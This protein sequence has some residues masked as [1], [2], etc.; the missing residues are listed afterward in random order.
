MF[1]F[2]TAD[3]K[4]LT[5]QQRQRYGAV[6][7]GICRAIRETANQTARLSLQYDMAFLALLLSSLYEPEETG[8]KV[9]CLLHPCRRDGWADNPYIRYAADLNV[10]LA[11]YKARDDVADEGKLSARLAEPVLKKPMAAIEARW[12]RQTQA[13]A[14]CIRQLRQLEEANCPNPDLPAACFGQLMAQLMVYREDHWTPYLSR[15]GDALGRFIYLADAALDYRRDLKKGSYN[16]F[17]ATGEDWKAWEEYLVLAMARCTR[18]YEMLP[19]IRDQEILD[20]IL[21]RGV[22][23]HFKRKKQT[24]ENTDGSL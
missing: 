1:G 18:A 19:L 17:H 11:Y 8:G 3:L 9:P 20:N 23:T 4:T 6:Y 5:R 2:V 22:W 12:P 21:Y 13:I 10:A 16:P 14:D 24:E 15:L 7:C